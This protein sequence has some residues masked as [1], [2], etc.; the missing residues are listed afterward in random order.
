MH[1]YHPDFRRCQLMD[2]HLTVHLSSSFNLPLFSEP[3]L[4][5]LLYQT[6]AAKH[7]RTKFIKVDV[8]NVPFLV[9]KLDVKVL[10][11]VISFIDGVAKDKS[12]LPS[13]F[14]AYVS[15]MLACDAES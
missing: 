10:P 2:K 14:V 8:A 5:R 9:V 4:I 7:L 11:C 3:V 13:L 6:L 1:F 12:V 15:I